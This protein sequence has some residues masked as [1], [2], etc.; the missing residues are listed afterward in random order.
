MSNDK[1]TPKAIFKAVTPDGH[2]YQIFDD[3]TSE[4]FPNGTVVFNH[5]L[6][7]INFERGL[8]IQSANN[9][10]GLALI[11]ATGGAESS[12]VDAEHLQAAGIAIL[13]FPDSD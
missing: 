3:G 5:W 7:L 10:S 13:S 9:V 4:G 6:A 8:R 2:T 11:G 12:V 1:E